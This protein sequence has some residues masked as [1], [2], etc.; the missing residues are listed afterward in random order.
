[1]KEMIELFKEAYREDKKTFFG[2]IIGSIVIVGFCIFTY[3][4]VGTFCYDM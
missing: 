3:W 4:F 1:M 2:D